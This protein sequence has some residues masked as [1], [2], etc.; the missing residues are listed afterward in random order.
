VR[1]RRRCVGNTVIAS[2]G[3]TA[4]TQLLPTLYGR[5]YSGD[6]GRSGRYTGQARR[7]DVARLVHRRSP[8]VVVRL[9][10]AVDPITLRR[11][12]LLQGRGFV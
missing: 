1:R 6:G 10:N 11:P 3:Q 12:M 5:A 4:T 8:S 2:I 7:V 9:P